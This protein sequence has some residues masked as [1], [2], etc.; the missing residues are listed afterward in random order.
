MSLWVLLNSVSPPLKSCCSIMHDFMH[1]LPLDFPVRTPTLIPR[2]TFEQYCLLL[3]FMLKLALAFAHTCALVT[4]AHTDAHICMHEHFGSGWELPVYLINST[5]LEAKD[6]Q[7]R[8]RKINS[9]KIKMFCPTSS[10]GKAFFLWLQMQRRGEEKRLV[11]FKHFVLST[12][13]IPYDFIHR[14]SL[15]GRRLKNNTI[16]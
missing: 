9:A 7:T 12:D 4:R 16:A 10:R 2:C 3:C 15:H 11:N 1:K 5:W 14:Y 13:P 6:M 8:K